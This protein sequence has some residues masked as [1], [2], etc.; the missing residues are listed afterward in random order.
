MLGHPALIYGMFTFWTTL[1][2]GILFVRNK[3]KK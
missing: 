1:V 3:R 2:F